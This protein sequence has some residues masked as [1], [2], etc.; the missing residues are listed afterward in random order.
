M[1]YMQRSMRS[2]GRKLTSVGKPMTASATASLAGLGIAAGA[3]GAK[4]DEQMSKVKAITG[5]TGKE[6][7]ALRSQAMELGATTQFS[8][9]QA[10]EGMEFLARAGWKTEQ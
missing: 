6:F 7:D 5:A 3:I 4:F 8:A 1:T 9:S 10:A 2:V